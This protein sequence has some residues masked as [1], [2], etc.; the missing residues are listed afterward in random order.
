MTNEERYR[1]HALDCIR[2]ASE[3]SDPQSRL[4]LLEMAQSWVKL[5]A[6]ARKSSQ[7]DLVYETPER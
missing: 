5:A 2:L 7:T 3:I 6:Q 1:G 4:A